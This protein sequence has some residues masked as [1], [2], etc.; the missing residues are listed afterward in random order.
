MAELVVDLLEAIEIERQKPERERRVVEA[1]LEEGPV[2]KAG[3]RIVRGAMERLGAGLVQC[4]GGA[5]KADQQQ[6]DDD[7]EDAE[8]RKARGQ[9]FVEQRDAGA[10]RLPLEVG[11][12]AAGTV[13]HRHHRFM[14]Q[15]VGNGIEMRALEQVVVP[16]VPRNVAVQQLDRDVIVVLPRLLLL[17]LP[18]RDDGHHADERHTP[19]EPDQVGDLRWPLAVAGLEG[20]DFGREV[21]GPEAHRDRVDSGADVIVRR[22]IGGFAFAGRVDRVEVRIEDVDTL[23]AE[24]EILAPAKLA[25]D[26]VHVRFVAE[27]RFGRFIAED[28]DAL[29]PLEVGLRTVDEVRHQRLLARQRLGIGAFRRPEDEPGRRGPPPRTPHK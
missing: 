26:P 19:A 6:R 28:D 15:G 1:L 3:E 12:E 23:V 2:G 5:S 4:P 27:E 17:A 11:D 22:D 21:G 16:H 8:K 14:G 10:L 7:A 24:V 29:L 20:G 18:V 9:R 13:G 25:V